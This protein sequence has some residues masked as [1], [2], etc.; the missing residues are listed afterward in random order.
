MTIDTLDAL[1]VEELK[2]L[3]DAEKQLVRALPKMAKAASD[4]EL[5]KAFQ[6][7]LEQTKGHVARIEQVFEHLGA[8]AKSKPCAA[9]KGLVQEGS[10]TM[11]EDASDEI[12]DVMLITAAQKVEHYEISAYG[13]ARAIA[14]QLQNEEVVELLRQTLD[15]EKET[16][17]K[18]TEISERILGEVAAS[19][20]GEEEGKRKRKKSSRPS[21]SA[22]AVKKS[23]ARKR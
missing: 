12:L 21:P 13:T 2:D 8:K 22:P 9:M 3:Y 4:A 7:H 20:G 16:D 18:L 14:E 11:E 23:A 19:G 17:D 5:K 15:E 10:E 1:L 6:Q